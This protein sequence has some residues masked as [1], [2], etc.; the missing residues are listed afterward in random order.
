MKTTFFCVACAWQGG[1]PH[2]VT[3]DAGAVVSDECP[4]CAGDVT[5]R[6]ADA[7]WLREF[8]REVERQLSALVEYGRQVA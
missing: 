6:H 4:R 8:R 5:E 1:E 2:V 7:P 3:N